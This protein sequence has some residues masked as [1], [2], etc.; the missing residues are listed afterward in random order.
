MKPI[1]SIRFLVLIFS[2]ALFNL[3]GCQKDSDEEMVRMPPPTKS[4]PT[5]APV[6]R[7]NTTP[8][9]TGIR[10]TTPVECYWKTPSD[11]SMWTA[12]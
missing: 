10:G 9:P 8:L 6:F 4:P 7:P 11:S 3:G 1:F 2:I 12:I 5:P